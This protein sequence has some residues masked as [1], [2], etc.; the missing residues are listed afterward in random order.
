MNTPMPTTDLCD[1]NEGALADGA[2]RVFDPGLI[3]LGGRAAFA[4]P[5]VTLKVF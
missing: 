4:G 1:A 5:A 2:L 3:A